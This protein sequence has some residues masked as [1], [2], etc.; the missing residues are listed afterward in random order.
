MEY[1][2]VVDED[3]N[4]TGK[5]EERNKIHEKNLWHREVAVWIM[6]E[7]GEILLQKRSA[8]KL[9][10]PNKWAICA[11]HIDRGE[12]VESA[13]VREMEEE[14]GIKVTIDELE[15]LCTYKK[16]NEQN[17]NFQYIYFLKTN[18]KI[19]D[20]TIREEEVSKIKYISIEELEAIVRNEDET[21]TFAK[22]IYMPEIIEMLKE[23]L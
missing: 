1:L 3:N 19:E 12:E 6:N 4:L 2:D 15:F 20:Y 14:I 18:F 11:G 9:Q 21:V 10:G 16:Q 13:I 7:K 17:Y 22:Q 23:R 8:N 5:V